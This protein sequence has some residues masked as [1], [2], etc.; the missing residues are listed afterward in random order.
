MNT[1]PLTEAIQSTRAA[2]LTYRVM[3]GIVERS[4]S[5][6]IA[7]DTTDPDPHVALSI[8]QA[9]EAFLSA[10]EQSGPE[11]W[12]YV[13]NAT[14]HRD[15]CFLRIESDD[16]A[17]DIALVPA[18]VAIVSA[19]GWA[20]D[21]AVTTEAGVDSALLRATVTALTPAHNIVKALCRP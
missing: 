17:T 10:R 19:H 21:R 15:R 1:I 3:T 5:I 2:G 20:A 18:V 4:R 8:N 6:R 9:R 13:L 11:R 12:D 16:G 7:L 14:E